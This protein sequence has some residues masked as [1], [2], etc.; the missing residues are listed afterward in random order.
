MR[1][2][3]VIRS[4]YDKRKYGNKCGIDMVNNNG[5]KVAKLKWDIK[6]IIFRL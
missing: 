4:N 2:M 3:F 5:L 1:R 6:G